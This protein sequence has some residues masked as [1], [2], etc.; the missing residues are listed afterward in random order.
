M[1]DKV[2]QKKVSL[3]S[4]L[5]SLFLVLFFL[6]GVGISVLAVYASKYFNKQIEVTDV[7]VSVP[8]G[9]S[10]KKI[11]YILSDN[12]IINNPEAFYLINKYNLGSKNLFIKAGE[13]NFQG[14]ISPK[15]VTDKMVKG[16]TVAYS[17]TI[18]E[19]LT[20][21]EILSLINSSG[22]LI[23]KINCDLEEGELLPE[24]YFFSKYYDRN[25]LIKDMKKAM[26]T[27]LGKAWKNRSEKAI[28]KNKEEALILASII[29]KETGIKGER[30]RVSAV[31][32]NRLKIDMPLQTDPTVI[33]A[34]T[35]GKY[36]L[37]R[38]LYYKDLKIDSP[39]NT[40]KIKGLPPTPIANPGK[41]AIEAALNPLDTKE[42]YFVADGTGGHV[43]ANTYKGH[44][45]NVKKWRKVQKTMKN[46]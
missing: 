26:S 15:E 43:F 14:N 24:T 32:S 22:N 27:A 39:Y 3:I 1:N 5:I 41:K 9:S 18:A 19:G 11:S 20:T 10:L 30:R 40:Y 38:P 7:L 23:G 28:V 21:K 31:F 35:G 36:K 45:K 13:Y 37:D 4:R 17:I 29:E 8:K 16:D 6:S 33:Y 44:L 42:L 46:R 2:F 25:K 34:I 12:G